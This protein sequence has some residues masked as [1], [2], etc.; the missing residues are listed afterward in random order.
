VNPKEKFIRTVN[1]ENFDIPIFCPA[2]Y[3]Y[4]IT[5]SNTALNLFG[6]SE[7]EFIEAI[8]REIESLQSE[9][10]TCGY[11]IY[12]IEAEAIGA[13]V[14]RENKDVFPDITKPV[15][16]NLNE[17]DLLPQFNTLR[18]RMSLMID[19]TDKLHKKYNETVYIRGAVSGPFSLAGRIYN[20]EKLILDCVINSEGVYQLLQYS[21]DVIIMYLNG[22]LEKGLDV[23][24]F[25]SLAS[26]P[27]LSPEIYRDLIWPFHR[28]IFEFMIERGVQIRPLIMGGNTLPVIGYLSKTGANQLLL[29]YIVPVRDAKTILDQSDL[30]YRVNIDPAIIANP[31]PGNI[32]DYLRQVLGELNYYPNL[33]LGTGILMPNVLLENIQ[34]VRNFILE[35]YKGFF[36]K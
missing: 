8:D 14:N 10:V 32:A 28:K 12:N 34:F 22:Y 4:K 18:G 19:I 7:D 33:L 15:I 17:V 29:D 27:L 36:G 3:D 35:H 25:D 26:P 16:S 31:D 23:V 1:K 5:F 30:A 13:V 6:Q 9:V 11:D 21:T 2:I 20:K 24:V